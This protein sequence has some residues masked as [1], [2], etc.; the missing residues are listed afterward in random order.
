MIFFIC[1]PTKIPAFTLASDSCGKRSR[2]YLKAADSLSRAV[3]SC[4]IVQIRTWCAVVASAPSEGLSAA[5]TWHCSSLCWRTCW[6]ALASPFY[7]S[8]PQQSPAVPEAK[9]ARRLCETALEAHQEWHH[10]EVSNDLP[11]HGHYTSRHSHQHLDTGAVLLQVH[12][13]CHRER[14]RHWFPLWSST[15]LRLLDELSSANRTP[16]NRATGDSYSFEKTGH[17]VAEAQSTFPTEEVGKTLVTLSLICYLH[18]SH[19]T[20]STPWA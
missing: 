11:S 16:F 17:I 6:F 7:D 5:P 10:F 4:S 13:V 9:E 8:A 18:T 1:G 2:R 12:R 14:R 15:A 3:T 19:P 20:T